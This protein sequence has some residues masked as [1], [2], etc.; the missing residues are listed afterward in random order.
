MLCDLKLNNL[1]VMLPS[2]SYLALVE[3]YFVK[4]AVFIHWRCLQL[5]ISF[6]D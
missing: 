6:K 2:I 5:Q 3:Q 4:T 1:K